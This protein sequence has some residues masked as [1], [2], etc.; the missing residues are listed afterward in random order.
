MATCSLSLLARLDTDVTR[1]SYTTLWRD[2][3]FTSE[4]P[5]FMLPNVSWTNYI[6]LFGIAVSRLRHYSI[7]DALSLT[8]MSCIRVFAGP[9]PSSLVPISNLINTDTPHT[10]STNQFEGQVAVNIKGFIDPQG[11][12]LDSEYFHRPDRRDITWSIQVQG[13]FQGFRQF[14]ILWCLSSTTRLCYSYL[15]K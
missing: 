15:N 13:V 10:I 9:S 5:L 14:C 11:Q 1:V 2:D 3:V 8:V 12:V 6:A 7:S 4:T